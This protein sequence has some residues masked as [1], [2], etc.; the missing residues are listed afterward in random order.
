[1][2][3]YKYSS[4]TA[5][6][7]LT[8]E[9]SISKPMIARVKFHIY[10]TI[11]L[12]PKHLKKMFLFIFLVSAMWS[13]TVESN[14]AAKPGMGVNIAVTLRKLF[15]NLYF[16]QA[17]NKKSVVLNGQEQVNTANKRTLNG[18]RRHCGKLT[19]KKEEEE[20]ERAHSLLCKC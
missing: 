19:T 11:I 3:S 10:N 2:L 14:T 13:L 7:G 20:E 1:M 18:K 12:K 5:L 15:E 4:N 16:S 8:L 9:H 17:E 6:F